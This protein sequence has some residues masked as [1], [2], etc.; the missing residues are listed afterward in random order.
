MGNKIIKEYLL[1][2]GWHQV[3]YTP[4]NPPRGT[5]PEGVSY[6]IRTGSVWMVFEDGEKYDINLK[7]LSAT[8]DE[9]LTAIPIKTLPT[10]PGSVIFIISRPGKAVGPAEWAMRTSCGGHLQWVTSN[11]TYLDD[12][13]IGDDWLPVTVNVEDVASWE[14]ELMLDTQEG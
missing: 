2:R 3:N 4:D 5:I 8:V 12:E 7:L 10:K 9:I 11:I 14:L 13:T 6:A 1:H